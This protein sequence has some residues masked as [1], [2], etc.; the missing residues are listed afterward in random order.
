VNNQ[1]NSQLNY[2]AIIFIC[3]FGFTNTCTVITAWRKSSAIEKLINYY[4]LS[5]RQR[6]F[7]FQPTEKVK[8]CIPLIYCS[9]I[10]Q[11]IQKHT[12]L[13]LLIP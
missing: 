1:L 13:K 6:N 8:K 3:G 12:I 9:F 5:A 4:S 2:F 11:S 7:G 10:N